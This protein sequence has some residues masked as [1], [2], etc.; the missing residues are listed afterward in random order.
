MINKNNKKTIT[1]TMYYVV[2]L[3]ILLLK[4]EGS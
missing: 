4:L 1:G 2:G 3:Y